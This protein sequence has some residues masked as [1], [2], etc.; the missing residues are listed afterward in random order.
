MRTLGYLHTQELYFTHVIWLLMRRHMRVVHSRIFMLWFSMAM[1]SC[2]RLRL[3]QL[4]LSRVNYSRFLW[5]SS[6]NVL[7]YHTEGFIFIT[8]EIEPATEGMLSN[9]PD[10]YEAARRDCYPPFT[11]E[12]SDGSM[13]FLLTYIKL[14]SV[15]H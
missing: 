6:L 5:L 14:L 15:D 11:A 1:F 8:I 9:L 4:S 7:Y 13:S 10:L 12:I 2:R 3:L